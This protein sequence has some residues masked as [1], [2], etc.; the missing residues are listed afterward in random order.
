[1]S[2]SS[3]KHKSTS[4]TSGKEI[5]RN[6][7]IMRKSACIKLISALK[8]GTMT[9]G[10]VTKIYD[11]NFDVLIGKPLVDQLHFSGKFFMGDLLQTSWRGD[12]VLPKP[13]HTYEF[14]VVTNCFTESA[15]SQSKLKLSAEEP[16][17][18]SMDQEELDILSSVLFTH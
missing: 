6:A 2:N 12:L 14:N 16:K 5:L 10:Q 4:N 9:L 11:D 18:P 7:T 17:S 15:T 8:S 3:Y 13:N 1:M